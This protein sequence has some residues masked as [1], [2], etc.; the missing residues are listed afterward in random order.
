MTEL[1]QTRDPRFAAG[2]LRDQQRPHGL[3]GTVAGLGDPGRPAAQHRSRG[4]DRIGRI[5]LAGLPAGLAVGAVDL[6]HLQP[7]TTQEAGETSAVRAGA[8]DTDPFDVTQADHPVVQLG[9]PTG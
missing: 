6:N 7:A 5:G 8:F 1:V 4:L 2:S 3:H 9:E